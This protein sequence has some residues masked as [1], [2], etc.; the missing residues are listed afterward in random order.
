MNENVKPALM[1]VGEL[2]EFVLNESENVMNGKFYNAKKVL[3]VLLILEAKKLTNQ[4]C[5]CSNKD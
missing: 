4:G 3:E 5:K 2:K 1:T